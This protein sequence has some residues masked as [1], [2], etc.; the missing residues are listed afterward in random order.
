MAYPSINKSLAHVGRNQTKKVGR[1]I[2]HIVD[3]FTATNASAANNCKCF[4][5]N[6]M[7]ASADYFI[8]LDGSIWLCNGDIRNYYS[9]HCGASSKYTKYVTNANSIGIE[10]VGTGGEFTQA[11]KDSLRAL[12]LALMEDFDIPAGNVVR[13]YDCNTIRKL[14]PLA[15][16]GT[17]AK[18]AKWKELHAYVTGG[19]ATTTTAKTETAKTSTTKSTTGGSTVTVTLKVLSKG[20]KGSQ[21]KTLQRLLNAMGYSCGNVDGDFGKNTDAAVRKFQKAYGLTVDGYCGKNT[22]GKLLGA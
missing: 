7:N 20:S 11:Q 17:A 21:V 3:H 15:Y 9:W 5:N 4:A 18:D 14:C 6:D 1:K 22:W 13:H 12:H 19:K 16:C 8:D 10:M 2:T